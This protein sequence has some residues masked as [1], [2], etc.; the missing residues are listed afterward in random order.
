MRISPVQHSYWMISPSSCT[1]S[2]TLRCYDLSCPGIPVHV[3]LST[4]KKKL[5]RQKYVSETVGG[6]VCVCVWK[7]ELIIRPKCTFFL[8]GDMMNSYVVVYW[9][10]GGKRRLSVKIWSPKCY[11]TTLPF[12]LRGAIPQFL[13]MPL[14]GCIAILQGWYFLCIAFLAFNHRVLCLLD[15]ELCDGYADIFNENV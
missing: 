15:P 3:T 5:L 11:F 2:C 13:Q 10:G 7:E 9:G 12:Y 1:T 14:L 4:S 6:G 8:C